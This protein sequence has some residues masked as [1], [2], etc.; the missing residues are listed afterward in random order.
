MTFPSESMSVAAMNPAPDGKM[1]GES[2]S[3]SRQIQDYL[4][5]ISGPFLDCISLHIEVAPAKFREFTTEPTGQASAQSTCN[6]RMGIR[7]LKPHCKLHE[8]T[9]DLLKFAKAELHLS[10]R[11]NDR[12]LKVARMIVDLA[13]AQ[14]IAGD[15]VS[16]TIQYRSL[17]RRIWMQGLLARSRHKAG[18]AC[19]RT[20]PT[21]ADAII[22]S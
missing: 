2:R 1:P 11:G 8:A 4:G 3:S 7:L 20:L 6:A 21:A 9:L 19:G 18:I 13:G 15:R 12:I 14:E 17:G 10:V 22:I 5:C 16:E